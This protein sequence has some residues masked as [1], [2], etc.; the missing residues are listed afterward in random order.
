MAAL[1]EKKSPDFKEKFN[2]ISQKIVEEICRPRIEEINKYVQQE[3]LI[4][5]NVLLTDDLALMPPPV[6]E[7]SDETDE[8]SLAEE[9]D[10]LEKTVNEVSTSDVRYLL[11]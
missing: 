6:Q 5:D 7:C 2:G 10:Q 8:K 9:C 11:F 3:F 4:P 1:V